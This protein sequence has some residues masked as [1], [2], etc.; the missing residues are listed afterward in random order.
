M[1]GF[2]LLSCQCFL[3]FLP[4]GSGLSTRSTLVNAWTGSVTAVVTVVVTTTRV[5]ARGATSV[6]IPVP[7][8]ASIRVTVA[9]AIVEKTTRVSRATVVAF[10]S[11]F[12]LVL[13]GEVIGVHPTFPDE[14]ISSTTAE[15][16]IISS[17]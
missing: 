6:V 3:V 5:V 17:V 10:P 4:S 2:C 13:R 9:T 1:H 15:A 11:L 14:V 16:F 12:F 8:T 7:A